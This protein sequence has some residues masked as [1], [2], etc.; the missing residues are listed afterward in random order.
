MAS[1]SPLFVAVT[2]D[3]DP[4]ANRAVEGRADAVSPGGEA[5]FDATLEG[6]RALREILQERVL[7]ATFFWEG[8]TLHELAVRDARLIDSLRRNRA[9]EHG[10]HGFAHE[11]FAGR[12]SGRAL[13]LEQTGEALQKAEAALR[14]HL[15]E[16]PTAFRAPYCRLTDEL[17]QV[18]GERDYTYDASLTRRA[19]P[20]WSLRPRR[21]RDG[22][23]WELALCQ[24]SDGDGRAISGYLWQLLEGNRPVDDYVRMVRKLVGPCGGGLLQIALHPWHL[25]VKADGSPTDAHNGEL[26]GRLLDEVQGLEGVLFTTNAAYLARFERSKV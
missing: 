13:S 17:V 20:D 10:C 16:R 24:S 6:L 23:V 19:G 3:I 11:D 8:R 15:G 14:E 26:V 1:P 25:L 9:F 7:P 21:L 12:E 5:T 18:L 2:A 22:P 4:D